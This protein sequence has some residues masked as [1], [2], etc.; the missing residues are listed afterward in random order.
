MPSA[1]T[2]VPAEG[3]TRRRLPSG[4]HGGDG[5]V[6]RLRTPETGTVEIVDEVRGVVSFPAADMDDFVLQRRD[7]RPTYNFAVVV[8]DVTMDITHVIRGAGHLSNTPKQALVFDAMERPRPVFVHLPNVLAPDGGKLSKRHG[9]TGVGEL[10]DAGM[11]PDAIVNYLSLLG[12]SHPEEKEILS[13]EELVASVDLDRI[14]A[15]E[16]SYDP[17]KLRWVAAQHMA[18]LTLA[19]VVAGVAPFVD[20]E[21]FPLDDVSLPP[22]VEAIRSRLATFGEVNQHLVF[23]YPAEGA[24]WDAL[25]EEIRKD[26]GARDVLV[27]ARETLSGLEEWTRDGIRVALKEAGNRVGARGPGLF[28]PLRKAICA[29]ESGPDL[30]GV[31]A[32]VGRD[33]VLRRLDAA[34]V[35]GSV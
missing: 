6:L 13:V 22:A 31:A 11:L 5:H 28:H 21:R 9:A 25:R 4:S 20:R 27:A 30:G 34:M 26:P 16:M 23:A 32:A 17:E 14:R 8:D 10:R 29:S 33:E 2:P 3:W 24:A 15:S 18:A 1:G 19:E 12:W 7:G 35:P